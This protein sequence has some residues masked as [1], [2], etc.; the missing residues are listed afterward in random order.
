METFRSSSALLTSTNTSLLAD[1]IIAP[2]FL[3]D[4]GETPGT[5]RSLSS[6]S[7][8]QSVN[9]W[10]GSTDTSDFYQLSL[11]T[12]NLN[13]SLTNLGADA[14][15]RVIRDFNSNGLVDF[16]EV[17]ASSGKSGTR[18]ETINL[19]SLSSGEYFIEVRR[20]SGDTS[21][22]LKVSNLSPN[23]LLGV[24]TDLGGLS[25]TKVFNGSIN[26]NNTSDTYR[27]SVTNFNIFGLSLPTVVNA[28]LSGL[29]ADSDIRLIQDANGNGIADSGDVLT[30]SYRG[31]TAAE[32]FSTTLQTGTYFLQVNQFS[33]SADYHLGISTGDWFSSNLSDAEILGEAR[34]AYYSD[35]SIG[36]NDMIGLLRDAKDGSTIDATELNDLRA[37]VNNAA[38]LAMPDYVKVLANKVVYSDPANARS[39]FGNLFAGSSAAQMEN[40][41]GKWFL[42]TDRPTATGTYRYASGSLYQGGVSHT[43]IDQGGSADCYF[44]A[45]L[46]SVALKTPS[47]IYNMFT[48]N[49]DGSFTVRFFNNGVADYVT[50]DR[51]LPTYDWGGFVYANDSSGMA[52]NN[53]NNELWVALAEKAYAQINESGWIGQDNTNSYAG[54]DFGWAGNALKQITNQNANNNGMTSY[55]FGFIPI[56]DTV[57]DMWSA[58]SS[59]RSVVVN[60]KDSG[61]A[62]GIV[63]NHSYILSGY[64][65]STG[66]YVLYNP[67][68]GEGAT[69]ELTKAQLA[70]NFGSWDAIA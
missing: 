47:K 11:S 13:V 33:G 48:D 4:P 15:L 19:G 26:N 53:A 51:Y 34:Y 28:S 65:Y 23:N 16:G 24:E 64:N 5:A 42:G 25:G 69:V 8:T 7:N 9:G 20:Y 29:S 43:D 37:I 31:G 32:L 62:S 54:I 57:N 17:V 70:D 63:A 50:V 14:D 59:G 39:G 61:V 66:K 56:G 45:A 22:N 3:F 30:G 35:G 52:Y 18:D 12:S 41:I 46:G 60:T 6:L 27:F 68:G 40:L 55:L 1:S 10:V 58:F 21:Y 38:G 49:G 44:L 2:S 67:W 36:R